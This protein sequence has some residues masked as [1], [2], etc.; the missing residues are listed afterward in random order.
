MLTTSELVDAGRDEMKLARVLLVNDDVTSRLTLQ[1]V[2]QAGGYCVDVAASASE[3]VHKLDEQKY[4]LV[5]SDLRTE[6][7]EAGLRV[8]TH[9]RMQE[10]RPAT[11]MVTTHQQ[12]GARAGTSRSEQP[13][14]IED[15]DMA[16]LLDRV[17]SLISQRV[18]RRVERR[19]FRQTAS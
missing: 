16:Y 7:R 1:T 4:E 13:V 5:L 14:L 2:L 12:S 3:A 17:A 11:A 19:V 6:P 9:A 15:E 10:Y 8:L 18:H